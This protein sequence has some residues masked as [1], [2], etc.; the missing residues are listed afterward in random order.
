MQIGELSSLDRLTMPVTTTEDR[1]ISQKSLRS[2]DQASKKKR[3]S[4]VRLSISTSS[5]EMETQQVTDHMCVWVN[6]GSFRVAP[7]FRR[8]IFNAFVGCAVRQDVQHASIAI[9]DEHDELC[10]IS[11]RI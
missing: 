7:G 3:T 2:H 10:L 1:Y 11:T 8:A 4:L 6:Q 9:L 5:F